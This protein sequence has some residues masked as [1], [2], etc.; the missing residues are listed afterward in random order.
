MAAILACRAT[1]VIGL[2]AVI[3]APRGIGL[4]FS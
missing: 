1:L 2:T 3:A 4:G